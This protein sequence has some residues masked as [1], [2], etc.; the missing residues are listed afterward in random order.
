MP[1]VCPLLNEE[2]LRIN[3]HNH[4]KKIK[5]LPLKLFSFIKQ[6]SNIHVTTFKTTVFVFYENRLFCDENE[7]ISHE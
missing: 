7:L 4:K 5:M 3:F 1:N 2:L 6:K